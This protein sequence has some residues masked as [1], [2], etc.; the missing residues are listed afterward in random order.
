VIAA[1]LDEA[2][3]ASASGNI[4]KALQLTAFA[5]D[6]GGRHQAFRAHVIRAWIFCKKRSDLEGLNTELRQLGARAPRKLLKAC[7][8]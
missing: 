1:K 3:A 5:L 4:D 2:E 8:P 7:T 6:H